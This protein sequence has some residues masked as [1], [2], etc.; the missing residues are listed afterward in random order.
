ME[1]RRE[2]QERAFLFSYERILM[3]IRFRCHSSAVFE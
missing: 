2:E 3:S 1:I